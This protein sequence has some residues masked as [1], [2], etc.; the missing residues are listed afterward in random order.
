MI[1]SVITLKKLLIFLIELQHKNFKPKPLRG[2]AG[3]D[4]PALMM[5]GQKKL[6]GMYHDGK[7]IKR[8][9]IRY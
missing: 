7:R 3:T 9:V 8:S 5:V 4:P 2:S 1:K 6:G